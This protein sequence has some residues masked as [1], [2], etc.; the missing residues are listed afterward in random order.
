MSSAMTRGS[1]LGARWD[2]LAPR[3]RRLAGW[4]I[5]LIVLALAWWLALA[6]ALRTLGLAQAEHARLDAQLR[7]MSTLAAQAK[8]LQGQ[9]KASR[10]DALRALESSVRQQL[11][12][13][14]QLSSAGA[15]DGATV[16]LR[17]VPAEALA[18]WLAQARGNA[19]ALPSEVHLTRAQPAPQPAGATAGNAQE[20]ARLRWDGTLVMSL[21]AR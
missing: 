10:D 11:G 12:P 6:P 9:P 5:A 21:P 15:G 19:R 20:P 1:A 13:N 2:A 17:G 18:Q 16:M 3:E 7:Q 4:A 8:A 14:A